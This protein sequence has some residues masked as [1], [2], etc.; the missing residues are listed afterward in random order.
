ML[1]ISSIYKNP[2]FYIGLLIRALLLNH[3]VNSK[4]VLDWYAPFLENSVR[5]FSFDPWTAWLASNGQPEAFPYGYAM[6]L[7]F[8][9]SAIFAKY[10]GI[11][12]A[13]SY[14]A[15]LLASDFVMLHLLKIFS[16]KSS[17]FILLTYWLSP[18]LILGTYYL[19]YNDIIPVLFLTGSLFSSEKKRC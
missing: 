7:L 12:S 8:L 1:Q 10:F 17:K 19:G 6:W 2:L 5:H 4:I 15:T 11:A 13:Y 18:I 9:P 14:A 3:L 16:G